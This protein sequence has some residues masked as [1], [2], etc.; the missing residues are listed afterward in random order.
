LVDAGLDLPLDRPDGPDAPDDVHP[1]SI[2]DHFRIS[3]LLGRGGMGSV[4]RA[5]DI[6]LHRDVA[7]KIVSIPYLS[8]DQALTRMRREARLLAQARH[9]HIVGVHQVG[10]TDGGQP[11]FVMDLI[12]GVPLSRILTLVRERRPA[13]LRAADL[14]PA[15][16]GRRDAD[17]GAGGWVEAVV[18]LLLPIAEAL[19]AAHRVGVVHCDVKPSNILVDRQGRAH[20]MDFGLARDADSVALSASLHG[21]GSP[22]YMAPEQL[23]GGAGGNVTQATDVY[24]LGATL[25]EALTLRRPFEADTV[26]RTLWL[27]LHVDPRPV[28]AHNRS[29]GRDL[30]TICLAALEK[31]PQ[32]RYGTPAELAEDLRRALELKPIVRR[33]PNAVERLQRFVRRNPWRAAATAASALVLGVAAYALVSR[34]HE[35]RIERLKL[36]GYELAVALRPDLEHFA[37]VVAELQGLATDDGDVRDLTQVLAEK[38]QRELTEELNGDA[39][40]LVAELERLGLDLSPAAEERART[41]YAGALDVTNVGAAS[42]PSIPE[43]NL[44]FRRAHDAWSAR[45]QARAA[46][47]RDGPTARAGPPAGL[48][49]LAIDGTPGASVQL[50]RY[51]PLDALV[52]GGETR[53]VP[54][55]LQHRSGSASAGDGPAGFEPAPTAIAPGSDVLLVEAVTPGSPAASA[56]LA[57]GDMLVD[58]AGLGAG[59]GLYA[60]THGA[61]GD[62]LLRIERLGERLLRD[63]LDLDVIQARTAIGVELVA[64]L[65]AGPE[66]AE[67]RVQRTSSGFDPPLASLLEI[68]ERQLPSADLPLRV[69]SDGQQREV[70]LEGP[71]VSGLTLWPTCY[72]LDLDPQDRVGELPLALDGLEPGSYLLVVEAPDHEDLRLPVRLEPDCRAALRADLLP[73]GTSLPGFVYIPPGPWISGSDQPAGGLL[74]TAPREERWLG[75][76]WISRT[77]ITVAQ[78]AEFLAHPST[79]P[80]IA[81]GERARTHQRVPRRPV[82]DRPF[83]AKC[84]PRWAKLG[85]SYVPAEHPERPVTEISCE[86]A[87]AYC[88]WLTL[89]TGDGWLFRLPTEDE[90]ERAA[91]GADGRTCPWGDV[92]VVRFARTMPAGDLLANASDDQVSLVFQPVRR[93]TRDES[94]FGIR[95]A[96]GNVLEWCTG[97]GQVELLF[98]RPWRGGYGRGSEPHEIVLARRNDGYPNRVGVNDGFRVMAW[99]RDPAAVAALPTVR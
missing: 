89:V 29:V 9:P 50:F 34:F 70:R 55:P 59:A 31:R 26:A 79:Q 90:W 21:S 8:P 10:Q 11:Y 97:P 66:P 5:R 61:G 81:D 91:R 88:H 99:K 22:P 43:W 12:D 72:P 19:Q 15:G 44:I 63:E 42:Q 45:L 49:A 77:E 74:P 87:D 96:A 75:G 13:E 69:V 67:I 85:G 38:R 36:E 2:V 16:A 76:Y 65:A 94:P 62:P 73:A 27:V 40:R 6:E 3:E 56:G 58:V 80:A 7:L 52:S 54:V 48:S 51:E 35:Q 1:G 92:P 83:G 95:D 78:Y 47:G 24:A 64:R 41:L 86:D 82:L 30:E 93:P 28:R 60:A 53:L 14:L 32:D 33:P 98:R 4:Y 37:A 71:G 84:R 25:Y 17:A 46:A 57:P 18:R 20:L 68:L 23:S 39:R